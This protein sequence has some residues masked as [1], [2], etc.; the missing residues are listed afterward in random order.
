V[1]GADRSSAVASA[2]RSTMERDFQPNRRPGSPSV[3]PAA[4]HQPA[5]ERRSCA[6]APQAGRPR[7]PARRPGRR[8]R[9]HRAVAAGAGPGEHRHYPDPCWPCCDQ[10]G[11]SRPS[12]C[13]RPMAL[14]H[15]RHACQTQR[16]TAAGCTPSTRATSPTGRPAPT[17]PTAWTRTAVGSVYRDPPPSTPPGLPGWPGR[18]GLGVGA[19]PLPPVLVCVL[20]PAAPAG[21]GG[22][23]RVPVGIAGLCPTGLPIAAVAADPVAPVGGWA[24]SHASTAATAS[25]CS[26]ASRRPASPPSSC[27]S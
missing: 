16:R 1:G 23:G 6:D 17:S 10:P 13:V 9:S 20:A 25:V 21:L 26:C 12:D 24:A 5:N 3:P 18:F 27:T 2:D 19:P 15:P 11:G 4:S 7:R 14:P 8:P 22:T